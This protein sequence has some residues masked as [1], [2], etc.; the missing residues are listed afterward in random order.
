MAA[1]LHRHTHV[2]KM[3]CRLRHEQWKEEEEDE[4]NSCNDTING[5][6]VTSRGIGL[7]IISSTIVLGTNP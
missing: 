2:Q 6:E 1:V 5:S 7:W 3:I 4:N